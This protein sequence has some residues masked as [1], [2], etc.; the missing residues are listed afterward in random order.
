MYNIVFAN[1]KGGVAKTTSALAVG[2]GLHRMGKRV[3]FCD[4]DPQC[5]LSRVLGTDD[6]SATMYD[7]LTSNSTAAAAIQDTAKAH[8]IAAD[9]RL[10]D[11]AVYNARNIESRLRDALRPLA[12]RYDYCVID[13]PPALS[14]LTMSAIVAASDVIIPAAPDVLSLY[15]ID[16]AAETI[17]AVRPNNAA[18]R[19]GILL[20]QYSDRRNI[21]R[22]MKDTITERAQAMGATV[23]RQTIRAGVAVPEA[24][25]MQQ[26]IFT[27]APRAG[28]TAD[29]NAF[30]DEFLKGA[31]N[32]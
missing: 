19:V 21:D 27:S 10:A 31:Q 11:R 16:Q 2:L 13:T 28:V 1:Q 32:G 12:G 7:V 25:L 24:H 17:D 4:V 26:D 29:Y 3:L 18:L 6:Q 23:Y 9:E 20:T 8:I 14:V 5:N 22:T 15:G 30:I